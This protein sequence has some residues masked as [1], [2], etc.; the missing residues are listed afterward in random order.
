MRD[1]SAQELR[2][3]T[4]QIK[5][6]YELGRKAA[7][8]TSR[9][10]LLPWIAEQAAKL[11]DA[12]VCN[13]RIREGI[14]LVRGGGTKEGMELMTKERLRI[15]E[16][17]S[18]FIAKNRKP[19]IISDGYYKD[20][21]LIAA[22]RKV[23][24][25]YGFCSCLGVPMCIEKRVVGVLFVVSKQVKK[26][27]K[28]DVEMLTSFAAQAAIAIEN[29]RL[30]ENL[31]QEIAE[32]KKAEEEIKNK[33]EQLK[34]LYDT[35]KKITSIIAKEELLPW[36]AKQAVKIL[37]ADVC[38]YRL[39]QGDYLLRGGTTRKNIDIM[40]RERIKT[41]EG[42]SGFVAEKKKP[43][44]LSDNY[45]N[46][47]R[48]LS[49]HG[50]RAK[51]YGLRSYVG[52]PMMM[53]NEVMG[54]INVVSKAPNRFTKKDVELLT[55]FA[56][57]AAIAIENARLFGNLEQEIKE[58]TK[59][60]DELKKK[61]VQLETLWEGGKRITSMTSKEKLLP[62][63]ARQA[64]KLLNADACNYRIRKGD[65]LV[66]GGGTKEGLKLMVKEKIKIGE[67]LSGIIA[68][69]KK[70]L[71]VEDIKKDK[72]YIREHRSLAQRLGFISFL[73]VPMMIK[74]KLV[75]VLIVRTKKQ[76]KFTHMDVD[77]LSAFADQAAI[78]LE[79]VRLFQE[80]EK[81]EKNLKN[82]SGKI[83]SVREEE[84]RKLS[85]NLHDEFGSLEFAINSKIS[86]TEKAIKDRNM[87]E[88]ARNVKSI[89]TILEQASVIFKEMAVDLRPVDLDL[90][91]LP[92]ALEEYLEKF[93]KQSGMEIDFKNDI[94]G[95]KLTDEAEIVLYRVAQETL[96]NIS[97]HA[98]AN[99]V[100]IKLYNRKNQIRFNISDNG[101]GFDMEKELQQKGKLLKMGIMGMKERVES[102]GGKF[103]IK[104]APEKGTD[105]NITLAN[106]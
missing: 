85:R 22:H 46:D 72:R 88:A 31:K 54:V 74:N 63:I 44:I 8:M 67:S 94:D 48:H 18:G 99:R 17:L 30:F 39:K 34:T 19:V 70:P 53:K 12:E 24:K 68:R 58:R 36:I 81:S 101:K 62:W 75:G 95:L 55:S 28:T 83:L 86:I 49:E 96:N 37:D 43:L 61:T 13:Y 65:Y 59:A 7:S 91:G 64:V 98:G 25:K 10:K 69:E 73:G 27:T 90:V 89:K 57:Q 56:D 60:E 35:G 66:R 40:V 26:F 103:L 45:C 23:A 4:E 2:K 52:I 21:R 92:N 32:R 102:L 100:R 41:G 14:Y 47:L 6:L 77:I 76:K 42:L 87:Q 3:T 33:A 82:F 97:K 71:A 20:P 5:T 11:L 84:K 16:S 9:D 50:E 106:Q 78:A 80:L 1:K 105:I 38:Y 51:K 79:N 29:A 15:G 104:S 93:S